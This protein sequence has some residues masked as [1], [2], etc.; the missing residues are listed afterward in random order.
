[1]DGMLGDYRSVVHMLR[2][3]VLSKTILNSYGS[4]IKLFFGVYLGGLGGFIQQCRTSW[5]L[6]RLTPASSHVT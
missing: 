4:Y 5:S 1:M 3:A 6:P 2:K